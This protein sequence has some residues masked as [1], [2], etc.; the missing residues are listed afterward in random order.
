MDNGWSLKKLTKTI[1]MSAAYRQSSRTTPE[2]LARD[3]DN[4][5]IS[6]G[7]RDRLS[8]EQIRDQA[9]AVSGLVEPQDRRAERDAAAARRRVAGGVQRRSLA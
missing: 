2:K 7:P 4:R 6:R 5:L 1:V 9:L 3:P 8:A